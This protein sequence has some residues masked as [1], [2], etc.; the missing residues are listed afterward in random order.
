MIGAASDDAGA[1][2]AEDTDG[3]AGADAPP[4]PVEARRAAHG[5]TG[6]GRSTSI[7]LRLALKLLDDGDP[8]AAGIAAYAL[9]DR[10]DGKIID[11]LVATGG[12]SGVSSAR[13]ADAMKRLPDWPGQQLMRLRF[14]QALR[15]E[16]KSPAEIVN[17]FNGQKPVSGNG[18]LL[19]ARAYLADRAAGRC[20]RG[21]SAR[22]GGKERSRRTS[23][24]SI[25]KEFASLLTPADHKARMDRLLY[26]ERKASR[27][28]ARPPSSTRT[29]GRSP[30][31]SSR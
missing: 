3:P 31:P 4:A 23:K 12:Y 19:L 22:T 15:H 29:S 9:P 11:W 24:R 25:A 27:R 14:E 20:R 26:D 5:K 10:I 2:V 18:T 7:G 6:G 30:P 1:P 8:V 21:S 16:I 28:C 13:I 17:A